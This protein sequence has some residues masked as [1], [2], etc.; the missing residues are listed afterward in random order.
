MLYSLA[1]HNR[2]KISVYI[3]HFDIS[4]HAQVKFRE[5][6]INWEKQ[7]IKIRFIQAEKD[8]FA[9]IGAERQGIQHNR[10]R[11][12]IVL[13]YCNQYIHFSTFHTK[14]LLA[15]RHSQDCNLRYGLCRGTVV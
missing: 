15:A 4:L 1:Y 2:V 3:L 5:K 12:Q 13:I 7:L 10:Q 11:L 8:D 9:E 6:F 14:Y